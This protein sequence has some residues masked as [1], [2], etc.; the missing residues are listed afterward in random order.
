MGNDQVNNSS[1]LL[2]C[3]NR[4]HSGPDAI[5][6]SGV[7]QAAIEKFEKRDQRALLFSPSVLSAGRRVDIIVICHDSNQKVERVA[8]SFIEEVTAI[9]LIWHIIGRPSRSIVLEIRNS[10]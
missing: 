9:A 2:V 10:K 3:L 8:I 5:S 6:L 1:Y 4:I 7:W